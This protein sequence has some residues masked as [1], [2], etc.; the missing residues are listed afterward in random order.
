MKHQSPTPSGFDHALEAV[1]KLY[2][3]AKGG[4]VHS[5]A[6]ALARGYLELRKALDLIVIN[7]QTNQ[8]W[9]IPEPDLERAKEALRHGK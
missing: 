7:V 2:V 3:A 1:A 5:N 9:K 6:V 8:G 4:A